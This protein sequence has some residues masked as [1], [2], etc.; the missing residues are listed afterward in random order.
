MD[1][2]DIPEVAVH[3]VNGDLI[4]EPVNQD[5]AE[6]NDPIDVDAVTDND[7]KKMQD[8]DQEEIKVDAS[9]EEE[10]SEEEEITA[11]Q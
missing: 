1:F 11:D 10:S 9:S 6:V 2:E 5:I 8:P 3:D 7:D 4:E